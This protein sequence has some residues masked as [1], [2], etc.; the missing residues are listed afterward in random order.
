MPDGRM[1]SYPVIV[2]LY[3]LEYRRRSCRSGSITL[4][5]EQF[6][7]QRVKEALHSRV[8]VTVRPATHAT[9]Q[10]LLLNQPLVRRC[11]VL[12][13][14]IRMDNGALGEAPS[15]RSERPPVLRSQMPGRRHSL[16]AGTFAGIKPTLALYVQMKTITYLLSGDCSPRPRSDP[17][18]I[19]GMRFHAGP[20]MTRI[21]CV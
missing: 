5:I 3:V 1:L 8:I 17:N 20:A 14:S 9:T 6:N 12:A 11:A 15:E 18:N 19:H 7:F 21:L 4:P 10:P 2:N 13:T 16:K